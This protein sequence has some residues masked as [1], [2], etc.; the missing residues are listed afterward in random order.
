MRLARP[1]RRRGAWRSPWT[2]GARPSLWPSFTQAHNLSN[3]LAAVA[4]ARALG[5]TPE[6][7]STCTSRRS[8]ASESPLAGGGRAGR[9]CYNANPMSMRAAIDDLAET[10]ARRRVAVLGDMLELGPKA[11]ALHREIGAAR[12]RARGRPA[13]GSRSAGGGDRRGLPRRVA[14]RRRRG[15]RGRADAEPA[16]A[17]RHGAREGLARGRRSSAS[18]R[19]SRLRAGPGPPAS[20]PRPRRARRRA[21][22]NG[23]DPVRRHRSAADLHLPEPEVHR[24]PAQARVRPAHTRGRSRGPP[25][26]GRHADD[27]RRDHLP[28]GIGLRS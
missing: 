3:L 25:P 7:A 12:G 26:E 4:A 9:D 23:P 18:W 14:R 5:L 21:A 17:G 20:G 1:Q 19:R 16:R 2:R 22:L 11:P 15:G 8:A 28:G 27:G 10:P 13:R 6:G 24:V